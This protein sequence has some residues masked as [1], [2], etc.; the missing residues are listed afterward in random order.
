MAKNKERKK[1]EIVL[2]KEDK[3]QQCQDP[4]A[5][6]QEKKQQAAEKKEQKQLSK[7]SEENAPLQ[8]F[9]NVCGIILIMMLCAVIGHQI[10]SYR[11]ERQKSKEYAA[12]QEEQEKNKEQ[13]ENQKEQLEKVQNFLERN[14]I[15]QEL[16]FTKIDGERVLFANILLPEEMSTD[17]YSQMPIFLNLSEKLESD[18]KLYVRFSGMEDSWTLDRID[19]NNGTALPFVIYSDGNEKYYCWEL[20]TSFLSDRYYIQF[21]PHNGEDPYYLTLWWPGN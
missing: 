3:S 18:T 16:K 8:A 12:E 9:S 7:K 20:N 5:T 4:Q 11:M 15:F 2:C 1:S 6:G 13:L 21:N 19:H 17:K 14:D 10:G